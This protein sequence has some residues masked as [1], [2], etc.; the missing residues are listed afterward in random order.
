[1]NAKKRIAIGGSAANPPHLAH[2][3]IIETMLQSK[4]FSRVSWIVSG[5]RFDKDS[6]IESKHRVAM[7]LLGLKDLVAERGCETSFSLFLRDAERENTPTYKWFD[8]FERKYPD[9][10]I[11]WYTGADV[12]IPQDIYSGKCEVEA[13]WLKGKSLL[14]KKFIVIPRPG[15]THPKN[16]NLPKHFEILEVDFGEDF[17]G[18]SSEIR[19]KIAQGQRFEHLVHPEVAE[20]IKKYKLYGYGGVV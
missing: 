17:E 19:K 12:F 7:T 9:A 2:R 18:C 16:L 1:M 14:E 8:H 20:Y 4:M 15:L 13:L 10:E 6:L 5:R 3:K 11:S